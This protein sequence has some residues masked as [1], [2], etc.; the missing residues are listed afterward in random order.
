MSFIVEFWHHLR[1]P[2]FHNMQTAIWVTRQARL[3]GH[4][5]KPEPCNICGD[6]QYVEKNDDS[7]KK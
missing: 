7:S 5:G 3:Y 4:E 2:H 6:W 1:R